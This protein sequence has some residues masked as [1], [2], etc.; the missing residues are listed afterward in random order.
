MLLA[1]AGQFTGRVDR[2]LPAGL[3]VWA[4]EAYRRPLISGMLMGLAIGVVYYP[5]FLLPLWL[6]FYW[7]RGL[8]RFSLGVVTTLALLVASLP[9]T[10]HRLGMFWLPVQQ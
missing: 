4:V 7:Q 5:V 6:G 10:S 2:V 8:L 1:Y 3:V 9:F